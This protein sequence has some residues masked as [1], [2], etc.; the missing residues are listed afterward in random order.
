MNEQQPRTR[1][2][3]LDYTLLELDD[4]ADWEIVRANYRRLVHMWHPDRYAQRPRERI[5]AQQQF[6]ALTK[7]YTQ[8]RT[9]H[10]V[11]GRLPFEP[12][13]KSTSDENMTTRNT[14]KEPNNKNKTSNAADQQ[15]NAETTVEGVESGMLAREANTGAKSEAGTSARAIW[16]LAGCAIMIATLGV[17][18]IIDRKANQ[19]IIEQGREA[20]RDAPPSDFMPSASEIRRSEAKGAFVQ[21]TK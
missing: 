8:L 5:H 11:H 21:P 9:F 15:Q 7:A 18:F 10:R 3:K 20:I 1:D 12:I 13:K 14:V 16:M 4:R 2:F 6:I 19:E 17:F